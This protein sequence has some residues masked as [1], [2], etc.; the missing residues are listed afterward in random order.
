MKTA[1]GIA[2]LVLAVLSGCGSGVGVTKKAKPDA[3]CGIPGLV[4]AARAPVKGRG[5]CGVAKPVVV[6]EVAGVSLSR[7]S[8][9]NCGTA[10]ALDEWVRDGA[11]PA[12]GKRGGGLAELTVA[13]H[14]ACRTR[15]NQRGA[16]MSEHSRGNAIDIS[17]VVM[18]DGSRVTVLDGWKKKTDGALLRRLHKTACGPFGTVLGPN[19]DRH[20]RDHFHFDIADH[21]SGPY[22]R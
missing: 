18:A 19:S 20:H 21:R 5:S 14:Y 3:I 11:I 16:R 7:P 22:C 15:N 13:A 12:V 4:S 1:I 17:S 6:T 8:I 10:Q 2:G 9:M